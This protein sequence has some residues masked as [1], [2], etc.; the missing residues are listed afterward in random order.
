M[1]K[2]ETFIEFPCDF[3][4]KII[5]NNIDTFIENVIVIVQ[6]HFP[7]FDP[8]SVTINASKSQKYSSVTITVKAE[9]KAQLDALYHE[10]HAYKQVVMLL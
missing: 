10:L 2:Q 4:I 7:N 9:S 8:E 5:G 3:P 1:S 6:S